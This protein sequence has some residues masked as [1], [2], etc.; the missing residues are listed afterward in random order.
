[1]VFLSAVRFCTPQ[2]IACYKDQTD[3]AVRKRL[4]AAITC[5]RDRLA[6]LIRKQIEAEVPDMTL[7]KRQFLEWY[8]QQK[9]AL[10]NAKRGR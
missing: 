3:R 2:Q 4:T 7:N 9:T 10:D 1:M 5:I 6:T 8:D